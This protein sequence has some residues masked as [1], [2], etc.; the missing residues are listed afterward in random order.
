MTTTPLLTATPIVRGRRVFL[1]GI[2]LL[3][4]TLRAGKN[5]KNEA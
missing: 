5:V 1:A 3:P 4:M 2:D